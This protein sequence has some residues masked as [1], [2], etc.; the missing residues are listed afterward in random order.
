MTQ[1]SEEV[2]RDP[3]ACTRAL[4]DIPSVSGDEEAITAAIVSALGDRSY[5]SLQ[6]LGNTLIYRTDLGRDKR[7]MLA[8]HTDTVP[9][10]DNFP[11]RLEGDTL[12]GLGTSDMKSG[13][14]LA[15]WIAANLDSDQFGGLDNLPYDLS[16]AFYDC[17]EVEADR[18]GLNKVAKAHPAWLDADF[19]ILLEPTYGLVEAGC[20]GTLRA[21]VHTSGKRS[22][23]ARSWLGDNAIHHAGEVLN[24]LKAYPAAEVDIDGCLYREGLNA[25]FV[26]GGIAGNVIPDSCWVE[27]N[28]RFAPN[29]SVEQAFAHV[30]EI[31][32][33]F[34]VELTDSSP[35][36]QPGLDRSAAQQ[37]V[38]AAGGEVNAK[39]GWT[40]VARFSQLGVPAMNFGPGDPNLAHTHEE[41]VEQDKIRH[42][43]QVLRRYLSQNNH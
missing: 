30:N 41:H 4:C 33:G 19:A 25:V 1:L 24:R 6:R 23:S 22:H 3:V 42:C 26:N 17:E 15:L 2:L 8:G 20:Q 11:T 7:I 5:L 13:T 14:A 16:F 29:K 31:F 21:R 40:D 36:A 34:E 9:V 12:W 28:Y 39:L 37:F 38:Q 10:N 18:N 43:A 27:V 32:E 35:A